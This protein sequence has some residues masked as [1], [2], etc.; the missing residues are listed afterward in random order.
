MVMRARPACYLA[1]N[2]APRRSFLEIGGT[3]PKG[4]VYPPKGKK[5]EFRCPKP[6]VQAC[7]QAGVSARAYPRG[8]ARPRTPFE[9]APGKGTSSAEARA[10]QA[11]TSPRR[12]QRFMGGAGAAVVGA[13]KKSPLASRLDDQFWAPKFYYFAF[14]D[15]WRCAKVLQKEGVGPFSQ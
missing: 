10:G 3:V 14:W 1:V 2:R 4:G 6:V 12:P 8:P 13:V 9:S 5:V 15:M 7:G 11:P